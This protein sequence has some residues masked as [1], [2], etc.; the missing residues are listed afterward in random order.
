MKYL[1][2]SLNFL[3]SVDIRIWDGAYKGDNTFTFSFIMCICVCLVIQ[4]FPPTP[5]G[6][7]E[8]TDEYDNNIII[9]WFTAYQFR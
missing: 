6:I 1:K 4:V 3:H 8:R 5:E 7:A 2:I 9:S